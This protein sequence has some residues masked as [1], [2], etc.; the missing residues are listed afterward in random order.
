[1]ATSITSTPMTAEDLWRMPADGQLRELVRGELREMAP[2]GFDHGAICSTVARL[3]GN[4]V[5]EHRLGVVVGA[6]TGFVL[7]RTPDVVRGADAA[8]VAAGRIPAAGRPVKFFEGPPDLAVEVVSPSDTVEAI[9]E[10]VDDYL[11]AATRL[12]WLVNPRRRTVTVYRPGENPVILRDTD[13]LHG[14]DVV[15]G[16]ESV[17][18]RLFD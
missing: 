14:Q 9:D 1:M 11:A 17:V 13:T 3:L 5:F 18:A 8:F 7:A 16:F 4:H 12:V 6:E 10:K 2:A 15:P